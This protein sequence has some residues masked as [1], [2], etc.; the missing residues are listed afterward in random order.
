MRRQEGWPKEVM[1]TTFGAPFV[2]NDVLGD[3]VE[4]LEWQN[5]FL[6]VV[7]RHDIVPRLLLSKAESAPKAILITLPSDARRAMQL[8]ARTKIRSKFRLHSRIW[9]CKRCSIGWSRF[10]TVPQW[11]HVLIVDSSFDF[12]LASASH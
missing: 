10:G 12:Y 4:R 11:R 9:K 7:N 3:E 6:H 8:Q 2:G 5:A 1:C